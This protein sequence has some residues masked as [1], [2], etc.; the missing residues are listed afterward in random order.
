MDLS[1]VIVNWDSRE[2]LRWCL[3]AL[4]RPP[5]EG[6]VEIIVVVSASFD[7]ARGMVEGMVSQLH[8]FGSLGCQ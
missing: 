4:P 2:Y 1:I 6:S 3:L 8:L 5:F 7:G